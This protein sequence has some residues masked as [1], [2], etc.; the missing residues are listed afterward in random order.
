[1][2]NKQLFSLLASELRSIG[3]GELFTISPTGEPGGWLW[4]QIQSGIDSETALRAAFEATD[5]FKNR[6]SVIVEQKKRAAQGLPGYVMTPG[7]VLEYEQRARNVMANAGIPT[8]FYDEPQD[9]NKYILNYLSVEDL[10]NRITNVYEFVQTAA[11]EVR[12]A[13]SDYYGVAQG[14][15]ALAAFILDPSRTEARLEK[16]R[17]VAFAGGMAARFDLDITQQTAEQIAELGLSDAGVTS[18]LAQVSSQS[19]LFEESKFEDTD[20]TD[21][22]GI[23]AAFFGDA[24]ATL[25]LNRRL[26]G[27]QAVNK[28]SVGGAAETA[29]GLVGVKTAG[30][31]E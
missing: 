31:G 19:S 4:N 5:I 11:P 10:R 30:G 21:E 22:Q 1:M 14:D 28:V 23:A 7:E 15:A 13:F 26:A 3:L 8:W 12:Q 20:I 6:F 9:F 18:G 16:A 25:A 29:K 17:N 24:E 27:R 2:D